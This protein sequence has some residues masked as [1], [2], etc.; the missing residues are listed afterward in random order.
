MANAMQHLYLWSVAL[1]F[2]ALSFALGGVM[3]RALFGIPLARLRR[4][5]RASTCCLN[6]M[7]YVV[8][9]E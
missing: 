6:R 2:A 5:S 9:L 8:Q 1:P 7:E 3:Q 4:R